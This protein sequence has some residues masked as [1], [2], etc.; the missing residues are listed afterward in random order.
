[1]TPFAQHT[2]TCAE[3]LGY[4]E[5]P[6]HIAQNVIAAHEEQAEEHVAAR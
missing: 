3:L 4:E 6:S 5:C 1:M 2:A